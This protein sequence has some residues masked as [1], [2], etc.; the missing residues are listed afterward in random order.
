MKYLSLV[1]KETL[2]L[3]S[4]VPLLFRRECG[5]RCRFNGYEIPINTIVIVNVWEIGRDPKHW[6]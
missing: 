1:I 6:T 2:R 5:E 4:L 3:H